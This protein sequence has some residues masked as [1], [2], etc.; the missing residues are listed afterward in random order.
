MS[1]GL[2]CPLDGSNNIM[3]RWHRSRSVF[4]LFFSRKSQAKLAGKTFVLP[5]NE[6]FQATS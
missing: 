1:K 5:A 6:V 4:G 3:A 2:T